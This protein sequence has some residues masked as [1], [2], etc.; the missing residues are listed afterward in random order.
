LALMKPTAMLVNTS[1]GD[2]VDEPA[3]YAALAG[4]R[5]AAAALDVFAEEPLPL[6]SPLRLLDN[7]LLTPHMATATRDAMIA[8]SRACYANF[9]RLLRGEPPINVVQ[10]YSAVEAT[11]GR[12]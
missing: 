4:R 2:V 12:A 1:R 11:T 9:A 6:N 10:P 5:L 3:L 8:K 7:V